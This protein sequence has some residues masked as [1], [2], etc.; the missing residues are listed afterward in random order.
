M[1]TREI[2]VQFLGRDVSAGR[3]ADQVSRRF[4]T[5][6][7]RMQR[8]GRVA[9]PALVTGLGLAGVA[10]VKMA[11]RAA[12]DQAAAAKL[13][14]TIHNVTGASKGS[15]AATERWITAQGK[16]YGVAD[17]D[18]RPALGRLVTATGSVSKAQKLAALSMDVSAGTG[19]SLEQVSTA[20]ARAQNGNVGALGRLGIATKD[21]SGK[22]LSFDQIVKNLAKTHEGAAARAAE[23][24]RGRQ[25]RLAVAYG[26]LQEKIGAGLL[27]VMEKLTAIGL[28]VV[29]WMERHTGVAKAM[30]IGLAAVAAAF[31]A[32]FIAANWIP[33][34]IGLVVG[35]LVY[36]Y[37]KFPWFRKGVQ[38]AIHAVADVFI[39]L[40]N[41]VIGPITKLIVKAIGW[42][43]QAWGHM[44]VALSHVPGFGWA[45]K[46]GEAMIK[47][48]KGAD[49]LADSIRKIPTR[50]EIQFKTN[51]N[52]IYDQIN[53]MNAA[54]RGAKGRNIHYT[55][56]YGGG[57]TRSATGSPYFKGGRTWV[58]EQGPELVDLPRGTEIHSNRKSMGMISRAGGDTTVV[59]VYVSGIVGDRDAVI[60]SIRQGLLREKRLIGKEL[61]LA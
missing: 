35:A 42:Q 21:A 10:M 55:T 48:G 34:A 36:A 59:N 54:A 47:A 16:A 5:L 15:I 44:L 56:G 14:N 50:K 3:T 58:G 20:L 13:A 4:G 9:G 53:R 33:I 51:A 45:K 60:K 41:S 22:T 31:V 19:K 26:E 1:G 30:A 49:K 43:L 38:V 40:W 28:K 7:T 37:K 46:A 61:G 32:A 6:G 24:A 52:K 25:Q 17:D 12:E 23:T 11:T 39:W 27:P 57:Q 8:I 29:A 18:L 2:V